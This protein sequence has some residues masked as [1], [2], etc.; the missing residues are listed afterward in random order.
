MGVCRFSIFIDVVVIVVLVV[1]VVDVEV[2][3]SVVLEKTIIVE[4]FWD[5]LTLIKWPNYLVVVVLVDVVGEV[6]VDVVVE[7]DVSVL[8]SCGTR[9]TSGIIKFG[10]DLL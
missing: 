9:I 5:I 8:R 10:S 6:V 1:E 4:R 2:V 3:L 7:V